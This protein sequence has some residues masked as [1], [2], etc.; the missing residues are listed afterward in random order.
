MYLSQ[1]KYYLKN[2]KFSQHDEHYYNDQCHSDMERATK[3]HTLEEI[4]I[5]GELIDELMKINLSACLISNN[6]L[7]R[8]KAKALLE[9]L[10][11]SDES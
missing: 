6:S 3:K 10:S 5:Q 7:V 8:E 4:R 9:D 1:L 11:N 2:V